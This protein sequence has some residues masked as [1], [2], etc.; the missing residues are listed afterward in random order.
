MGKL[1]A[2][3]VKQLADDFLRMTDALGNYR[4]ENYQTL[5]EEENEALKELH[6]KTSMYITELYTKSAILVLDDVKKALEQVRTITAKTEKL[7][8][9]L[10]NVQKVIDRAT[11]VVGLA[12]AFVSLDAD[13]ITASLQELL[14]DNI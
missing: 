2:L 3:Q 5:S 1:N 10:T 4:Y 8:D 11:S 7:Y 13:N 6:F 14:V 12:A 9:K